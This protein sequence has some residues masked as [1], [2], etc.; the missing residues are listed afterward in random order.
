LTHFSLRES[1]F[2]LISRILE[3]EFD[4][5][6]RCFRGLD[7]NFF[8]QILQLNDRPYLYS[9]PLRTRDAAGYID[10]LIQIC[11]FDHEEPAQLLTRF[12]E[13]AVRNESLA[14]PNPNAGRSGG[15]M[16]WGRAEVLPPGLK[17]MRQLSGLTVTILALCGVKSVLVAINQK[18]IF[19]R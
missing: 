7:R 19:H 3:R 10:G 9:A 18:H 11:S 17:I 5:R 6:L 12:R 1:L 15:G 4:R 13:G 14:F 16:E 8:R 2:T